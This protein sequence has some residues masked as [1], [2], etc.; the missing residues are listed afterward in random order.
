MKS[1]HPTAA[2]VLVL[3]TVSAS[4]QDWLPLADCVVRLESQ[5]GNAI[6][7]GT[8]TVVAVE[9]RVCYVLTAKHVVQGLP[10][11]QV[12]WRD[13]GE[14]TGRVV[15]KGEVYDTAILSAPCAAGTRWIDVADEYPPQ[16]ASVVIF[17]Y[18]GGSS[19]LIPWQTTVRGYSREQYSRIQL[20]PG[21]GSGDSGGPIVYNGTLVGIVSGGQLDNRMRS[22]STHGPYCTPIRNLLRMV[23]PHGIVAGI[24][25]SRARAVR[26]P[27]AGCPPGGT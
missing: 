14:S 11:M 21:S 9:D 13:G 8:G 4:G 6:Y 12:I 7:G 23:L 16:G 2:F 1:I 26:Q 3:V 19:Q 17:G 18:R 25:A 20:E 24:D 27:S 5:Q 10:A 15:G 22:S